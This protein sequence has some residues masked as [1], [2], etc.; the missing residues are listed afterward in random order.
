[1]SIP[2][3]GARRPLLL[4]ATLAVALAIRLAH[5]WAVRDAPF[6]AFLAVDAQEYDRWAQR[7]AG[8]AWL[9][10]ET[11]FQ[12]PLYPY[13]LGG[14]YRLAGRSLDAVYLL[15][16]L[17]AVAGCWALYRAGRAMADEA[18]A[19]GAAALAALYGP[20]VFYDVQ[21]G[22]ESLAVTAVCFFM[23]MLAAAR[24]RPRCALWLAAGMLLGVLTL[25]REN[26]LLLLPFLLPLAW[27]R[28]GR[29]AGLVRRGGAL[30]LGL[31][32]ILAPVAVRNA[33]VGGA[34]LPTTSQGGV[35]L[36]IGN[37]PAA[38]GTYRPLVPGRQEPALERRA[39]ELLAE[40]ALGRALT[41]AE[42]SAHWARRALAWAADEPAAALRLQLRKLAMFWSWYEWPDAVDYY[43]LRRLSPPLRLACVEFGGVTLLA[44]AG[45]WWVRRR[46]AA[47]APALLWIAGWTAA[48]V[49]FFLF[50]RYR[51]PVVPALLLLAAHPLAAVGDLWRARRRGPAAALAAFCL[52][53]L[54][55][56]HAAG[57]APRMDLVHYNLARLEEQRGNA[58]AAAAHDRAALALDPEA[59]LPHLTLGRHAA[60][61]RDW[62]TA[63]RLFERAAQLEP[64][65]PEVWSNLGGVYLALGDTRRARRC[66]Q[67]ALALD[68]ESLPALHN[69]ALLALREGNLPRARELNRRALAVDPAHPAARRL[70]AR[71][72]RAAARSE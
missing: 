10:E 5:W 40:R 19:L 69:L 34:P 66:L 37:N 25:L 43:Y 24:S 4:F 45:L 53:A 57:Y 26:A 27:R 41:P 64:R 29:I 38:D 36:Y 11:F 58:D 18:V 8:G 31:A 1:M 17:L 42:V 12:A 35:N 51:L 2:A 56:P 67:Q 55:A 63:L 48:T 9:G 60:R 54:A 21:V 44:A 20:F 62:P 65:S 47:M 6:V 39:P 70:A 13:L 50:S 52:V 7:I 15:Q 49:V 61:R 14:L 32:A 68:P 30:I 22:K 46:P 59:F 3:A 23:W 72:A 28:E 71:L 33:M 16:I